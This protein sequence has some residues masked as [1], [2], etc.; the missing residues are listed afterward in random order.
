MPVQI[1]HSTFPHKTLETKKIEI[2]DD[3]IYRI[4]YDDDG[5]E[6]IIKFDFST[7]D[8]QILAKRNI[9]HDNVV[10]SFQNAETP[11]VNFIVY[12]DYADNKHEIIEVARYPHYLLF[13]SGET[14][15]AETE[16]ATY[17]PSALTF[18]Q[19]RERENRAL[20]KWKRYMEA[21]MQETAQ[22]AYYSETVF[23]NVGKLLRSM[24]QY[25]KDESQNPNI[26]PLVVAK[27]AEKAVEG[28]AGTT[29]VRN[30]IR[31]IDDVTFHARRTQS[32]V[33]KGPSSDRLNISHRRLTNLALGA[34]GKPLDATHDAITRGWIK[35]NR[36]GEVTLDDTTPTQDTAVQATIS[37]PDGGI[38]NRDY[39]WQKRTSDTDDWE[40]ISGATSQSYT[41]VAGDVGRQLRCTIAYNDN[42]NNDQTNKNTAASAATDAVVA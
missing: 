21:I 41:P 29:L 18:A 16:T 13:I 26:D 5:T 20:R 10:W 17:T 34:A 3:K 38:S 25:L 28:P 35:A 37:D 24:D 23:A 22:L 11:E 30:Q 1:R 31:G 33:R 12:G 27:L 4:K 42:A 8:G 6:K 32:W 7:F 2:L 9:G 36:D 15:T 19:K 39:Q 14:E 40:N